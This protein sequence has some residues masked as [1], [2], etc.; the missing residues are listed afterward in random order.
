MRTTAK[1][2]LIF[3]LE[4]YFGDIA[5]YILSTLEANMLGRISSLAENNA[6]YNKKKE[7]IEEEF[8]F[9]RKKI[10]DIIND[11]KRGIVSS[12]NSFEVSEPVLTIDV[13]KN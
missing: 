10:L 13:K 9:L 5:N 3:K 1:D 11:K 2:K 8:S 6:D 7:L 4:T 12:L